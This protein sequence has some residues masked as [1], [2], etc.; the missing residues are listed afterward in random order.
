MKD[1]CLNKDASESEVHLLQ[2]GTCWNRYFL[3]AWGVCLFYLAARYPSLSYHPEIWAEQGTDFFLTSA[4]TPLL[5]GFLTMGAG[6][7]HLYPRTISYLTQ[8]LF[9]AAWFPL[10]TSLAGL[11]TISFIAA[12]F[13]LRQ[14][15]SILS[16]DRLRFAVTL[17]LGLVFFPQ[18]ESCTF[19]NCSYYG[20]VLG[21]LLIFYDVKR[22]PRLA[23]AG[24]ALMLGLLCASKFHLMV[25][26]PVYA[27][28]IVW[29]W[30]QG[31]RKNALFFAPAVFCMLVQLDRVIW[32]LHRDSFIIDATPAHHGVLSIIWHMLCGALAYVQ[33]Y[34]NGLPFVLAA[35]VFAFVWLVIGRGILHGVLTLR[36]VM[37]ILLAH[38]VAIG[39]SMIN[40]L[41]GNPWFLGDVTKAASW[42]ATLGGDP[43][44]ALWQVISPIVG[45][46]YSHRMGA[47]RGHLMQIA[48]I[49]ITLLG[50]CRA[51]FRMPSPVQRHA[52]A[53]R[54]GLAI[55][56]L[57]TMGISLKQSSEFAGWS[58]GTG[59]S[60]SWE[61]YHLLVDR[62]SYFVPVNPWLAEHDLSHQW[63][64][65]HDCRYL[66]EYRATEGISLDIREGMEN[67]KGQELQVAYLDVKQDGIVV[68]RAYGDDGVLLGEG[69]MISRV[70]RPL[71]YVL[72]DTPVRH[73]SRL[74]ITDA[75]G[76][77][78]VEPYDILL[79]GK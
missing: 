75:D 39:F 3:L 28:L 7:I 66:G 47:N 1:V 24:L 53:V 70:E 27:G 65:L 5:H 42:F 20:T 4:Y 62:P 23:Y 73:P 8:W 58:K 45:A 68:V 14:Y 52:K 74:E 56:C 22:L 34:A 44:G 59:R 67:A 63:A 16:S 54:W 48:V 19:I 78:L 38:V 71:K 37:F 15:R 21:F 43:Q 33:M 12:F 61:A 30:R 46:F 49:G 64:M 10:V 77:P 17:L 11:L 6:Y 50:V 76:A 13:N 35:A 9:P 69:R 40:G 72:F 18:Y 55:L 29:H 36:Q 25:F 60:S 51:L 79:V 57:W 32:A 31:D 2:E 26:L 41:H